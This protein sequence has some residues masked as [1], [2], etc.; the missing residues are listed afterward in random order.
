M[1]GGKKLTKPELEEYLDIKPVMVEITPPGGKAFSDLS[2]PIHNET[3]VARAIDPATI[4]AVGKQVWQI[5]VDNKPS[6][7]VNTPNNGV[8]PQ[9]A[10]FNDLAGWAQYSWQPWQWKWSNL[11]GVTVVDFQWSFDWNCRGNYRGIGK[12]IQNAGA[13][14]KKIDVA[15]GYTVSVDAQMLQPSNIGTQQSPV[16]AVTFYMTMKINT[17]IKSASQSCKVV[18]QGDCG[19]ILIFCD[20]YS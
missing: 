2:D 12:Y 1:V 4:I 15:W 17:V 5:I 6:A 10:G 7:T 8:I 14:P 3:V 9:G 13:F 20:Q 16:A 18:L 19:N 11:Y